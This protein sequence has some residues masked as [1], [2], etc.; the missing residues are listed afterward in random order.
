VP[1]KKPEKK[2]ILEGNPDYRPFLQESQISGESE[3]REW[4]QRRVHDM[5]KAIRTT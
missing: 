3:E 5:T 2:E 1:E 4:W